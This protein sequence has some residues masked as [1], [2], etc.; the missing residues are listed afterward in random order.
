MITRPYLAF[1]DLSS[2]LRAFRPQFLHRRLDVIAHDRDQ[3]LPRVI[4][5]FAFLFAVR[6]VH[7]H[8]AR[9]R[10]ED[11]PVLIEIFRYILPTEHV[12]QERP[13]RV[14]VVGVNQG[15]N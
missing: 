5:S 7:A 15:V 11:E 1:L 9:S 4:I 6:R 2:E 12:A 13:R 3:V 8:L 10:F 14:S